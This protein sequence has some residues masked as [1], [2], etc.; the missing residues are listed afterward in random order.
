MLYL[1]VELPVCAITTTAITS[2]I[3]TITTPTATTTITAAC[4][5]STT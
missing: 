2:D 3:I 1:T 5:T 4:D